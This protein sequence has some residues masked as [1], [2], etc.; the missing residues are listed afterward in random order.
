[1]ILIFIIIDSDSYPLNIL[2]IIDLMNNPILII[3]NKI[4]MIISMII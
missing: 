1:M 2:H 3:Y 4:R